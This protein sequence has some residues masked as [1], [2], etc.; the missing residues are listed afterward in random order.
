MAKTGPL[1]RSSALPATYH[2]KTK[3]ARHNAYRQ[4][5]SERERPVPPKRE[6]PVAV[7]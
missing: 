3:A 1:Y 4:K 2:V 6:V 5:G 7:T